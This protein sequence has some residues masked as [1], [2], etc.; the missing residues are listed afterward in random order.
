LRY[1]NVIKS[2]SSSRNRPK[3]IGRLYFTIS[4]KT[5][6]PIKREASVAD[7]IEIKRKKKVI[8]KIR[9]DNFPNHIADW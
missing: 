2:N 8:E 9:L 4:R 7:P 1:P 3:I 5:E 6:V